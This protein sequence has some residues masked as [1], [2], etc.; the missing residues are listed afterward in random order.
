MVDAAGIVRDVVFQNDAIARDLHRPGDWLGREWLETAT[1]ACHGAIEDLLCESRPNTTSHW[2]HVDHPSR[3]GGVIP[4]LYSVMQIGK[5]GMRVALGRDMRQMDFTNVVMR[6]DMAASLSWVQATRAQGVSADA[7]CLDILTPSAR[8]LGVM[9]TE[10]QCDFTDVTQ[11]AYQIQRALRM[12]DPVDVPPPAGDSPLA[13]LLPAPSEQHVLGIAMVARFFRNA[14]WYV[15]SEHDPGGTD[16]VA[17][18][19]DANVDVVGFSAS[20]EGRIDSLTA[21]IRAIRRASRNPTLR[22]MVGG[23]LF[24]RRPELVAAVGADT[25]AVDGRHAVVMAAG[26]GAGAIVRKALE[27]AA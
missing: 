21:M 6:Q 15:C 2:R 4:V 8:R 22:I 13:L 1:A 5:R 26:K 11:G 14:G 18:V 17:F 25:T 24:L 7:M 9:W 23:D 20:C 19:R 16:P 27:A 12:L 10:D 3:S